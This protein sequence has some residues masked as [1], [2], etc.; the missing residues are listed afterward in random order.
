MYLEPLSEGAMEELLT[1]LVPGLPAEVRDRILERAEGIPLYAVETV[2]MLLDRGLLAQ[3]GG[4]YRL[5]GQVESLEVPETLHALIA[6]RLDGLSADERRLL[7]DASVLGKTFTKDALAALADPSLDVEPLLAALARKEVLGVQADPRSPEHGQYGFLQDLVRHVAYET[8]SK[9]ERRVRHL[10]AAENLS[11][12]FAGEE[13]EVAEVIAAH[14]VAAYE[15]GPEAEEAD[16]IRLKAHAMLVRAGQR[17]ESLAAAA[18]ARRYFERAADLAGDRSERA[19]L[20]ARAGDMATRAAQPDDARRLLL[21]SIDLLDEEGDTHAAARVSSR[22]A[23]LERFTGRQEEG[24][25]RMERAFDVISGDE[26]DEDLALLAARLGLA[27]WASGDLERATERAELALDI[28]EAHGYMESIAIALQAKAAGAFSRG[29]LEEALGL[30]KHRLSIAL[31]HDLPEQAT[32]AYFILSDGAFHRDRYADALAYQD[33][34]LALVRKVG[35]RPSEWSLLAERTYALFMTGRWDE[36]LEVMEDLQEEQARSGGMFLSL[37]SGPLEIHLQRGDT[38]T[39]RHLYGLFSNLEGSTDL[40][41]R[42]CYFGATAALHRADDRLEE[43]LATG[44]RV[45]ETQDTLGMSHQAVEQ[46]LVEALEAAVALGDR[47]AAREVLATIEAV[48][49]ERR[50]PFLDAHLYRFH[51]R[52]D[53]DEAALLGAAARFREIGIPFWLAVTLL[54]HGELTGD[55]ASLHEAREIFEALKATRWLERLDA[56]AVASRD[57]V[58]A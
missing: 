45:T 28:A 7:Q 56:A 3:E 35:D 57:E 30:V 15:S 54:E 10:A 49:P 40:Q 9:R 58:P 48:P 26:P 13:D 12:A 24:L 20:L 33:E 53:D 25:A 34:A 8:L 6:A 27:Y 52:L 36:A 38:A 2:R 21:E 55:A 37:L 44:R 29:H 11:K 18:E 16:G 43:A 42:A 4:A 17:A 5:T 46:G 47:Q 1:G 32:N 50:P 39:A 14:Y 19:T 41:E 22:L 23:R 31:E 51:G